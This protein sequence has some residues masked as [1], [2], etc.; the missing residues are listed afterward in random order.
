MPIHHLSAGELISAFRN[1][2]LTPAEVMEAT[3]DRIAVCEPNIH[4]TYCCIG[5][6]A[7]RQAAK[8]AEE[9]WQKGTPLGALDGVPVTVKDNLETQAMPT[10]WGTAAHNPA[11]A[12]IDAPPVARLREAGAI[13]VAKT[14]MPDFGMLSSSLSSIHPLTRNP[15]NLA[16]TPGGSSSGAAA[17]AAAG[18]APLHLGTDIGGSLRLPAAWCGI[19]ALKPTNGR[20][21]IDPPYIGRVAGPMTRTV[22]DAALAMTVLTQPDERDHMCL[23]FQPIDWRQLDFTPKGLRLGLLLEAGCGLAVDPEIAAAVETAAKLFEQQGAVIEPV[24]PFL[25]GAMLDGIDDF[26]RARAW[27]D[28]TKM[29]PQQRA[30]V[31]PFIHQW[32]EAADRFDGARTFAGFSQMLIMRAAAHRALK[33]FDFLLSPTTPVTAFAAHL[34]CPTNDVTCPFEHIGFT[35]A[36][37]MSEQPAASINCGYTGDGLPIGLQIIGKR[38]DDRGVL[39]L[40]A[41]FE[42]IRPPQKPW[43]EPAVAAADGESS[44]HDRGHRSS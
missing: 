18:Y 37:N 35:V 44:I 7:A 10:Y 16:R 3:L 15:W 41:S 30:K 32:A 11:R 22:A 25:T 21:P 42:R 29:R 34:P 8:A 19:F 36:F 38:F 2:A 20:I 27:A 1:G 26:W 17:A 6:T 12:D 31:L 14:T 43:P 4:A 24:K 5:R 23:P 13:V 9:R 33:P 28:L 39:R 40:A